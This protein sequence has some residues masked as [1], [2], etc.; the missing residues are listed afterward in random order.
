M[1]VKLLGGNNKK[2]TCT[3]IYK[4]ASGFGEQD[5]T[6]PNLPLIWKPYFGYDLSHMIKNEQL[7]YQN[8]SFQSSYSSM[9]E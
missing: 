5:I 8:V 2:S 4:K 6:Y 7:F 1:V 9:W 3:N